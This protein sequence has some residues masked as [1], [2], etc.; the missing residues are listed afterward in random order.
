[1]INNVPRVY[2]PVPKIPCRVLLLSYYG[3]NFQNVFSTSSRLSDT[4]DAGTTAQR[5]NG[6][7]ATTDKVG[8]ETGKEA[9]KGEGEGFGTF[10]DEDRETCLGYTFFEPKELIFT[11]LK[12]GC[13]L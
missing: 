9:Q 4:F 11:I 3:N 6:R 8:T 7:G 13:S 10:E 1:M 2:L 12:R 5:H